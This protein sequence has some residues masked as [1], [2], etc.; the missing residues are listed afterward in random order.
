[1]THRCIQEQ[2]LPLLEADVIPVVTG[3]IGANRQGEVTTLGRGG[4]DYSAAILAQELDANELW[5]WKDV[6]GILTTDPKLL[7]EAQLIQRNC[8]I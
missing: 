1:M 2:L 8:A 6:D 7:P 4:S 5:I 3:F